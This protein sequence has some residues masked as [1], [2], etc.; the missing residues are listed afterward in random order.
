MRVRVAMLLALV[1]ALTLVMPALAQQAVRDPAPSERMS[2]LEVSFMTG[3]I[4]HHREAI[5]MAEMAVMKASKPEL[6]E[7]AAKIIKEQEEEIMK[8]SAFLRDWYGV[9]PPTAQSMPPDIMMRFDMP[10]MQGLMPNMQA[11]MMTLE[12]KTGAEFDVEFISAMSQH[13]GLATM[14]AS[15]IQIAGHHEDLIKLAN[16]MIKDQ[17]EEIEQ[18]MAWLKAWYGLA[19]PT[20]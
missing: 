1:L 7:L 4:P 6:R 17:T 8:M 3:M 11:R 14:M 10:V 16:K 20:R 12:Q 18:M 15:T 13:H 2:N 19:R 9:Q 5:M